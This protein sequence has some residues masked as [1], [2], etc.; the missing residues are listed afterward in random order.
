MFV[1]ELLKRRPVA[2]RHQL[3][4]ECAENLP[5]VGLT[6]V[7]TVPLIRIQMRCLK[8]SVELPTHVRL[9]RV[10]L[11]EFVRS[12]AHADGV[13]PALFVNGESSL[14]T[15]QVDL[16]GADR[17]AC[18]DQSGDVSPAFIAVPAPG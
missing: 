7:V 14:Q 15:Q 3:P 9:L 18:G 16:I 11:D 6:V 1:S 5:L 8:K 13:V 10:V 17:L 4:G 12:Q 2:S